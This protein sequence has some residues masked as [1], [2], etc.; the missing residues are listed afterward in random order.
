M[1]TS[2]TPGRIIDIRWW[3]IVQIRR[4]KKILRRLFISPMEFLNWQRLHFWDNNTYIFS[5]RH[6]KPI[7]KF[8]NWNLIYF[9]LEA[10]IYIQ[11]VSQII[12]YHFNRKY[13]VYQ[14]PINFIRAA[15]VLSRIIFLPWKLR[16][17]T[18]FAGNRFVKSKMKNENSSD[19]HFGYKWQWN[20]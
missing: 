4:E 8:S 3:K 6:S 2:S 16:N 7:S 17:N 18:T 5:L 19:A 12:G 9:V 14:R 1:K 20:E 13:A 11:K 10:I 15:N